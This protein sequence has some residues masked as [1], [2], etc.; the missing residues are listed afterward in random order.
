MTERIA[1][2]WEVLV[3]VADNEGKE[4]ALPHHHAWDD[5]VRDITGGLTIMRTAKGQW[6]DSEGRLFAERV[7]PVRVACDEEGVRAIMGFTLK[8]YGQLAV[9][10]YRISDRALILEAEQ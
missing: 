3:P 10:A 5:Q 7:I 8:H 2:L 4:F 6:H 1:E 9:M